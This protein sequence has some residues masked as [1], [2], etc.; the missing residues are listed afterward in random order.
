MP[1]A[2]SDDQAVDAFATQLERF[3]HAV[4]DERSHLVSAMHRLGDTWQDREHERFV[5]HL[6]VTMHAL[7]EFW[8]EIER[9]VPQLREDAERIR[10]Y[11]NHSLA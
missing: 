1:P 4:D 6:Q 8:D 3:K 10:A 9:V 7:Q 2:F 5:D 11:A